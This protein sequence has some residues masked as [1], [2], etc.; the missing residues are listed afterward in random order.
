MKNWQVL[1]IAQIQNNK[2]KA[3]ARKEKCISMCERTN[4]QLS[5]KQ[6]Q[7]MMELEEFFS[8]NSAW[9]SQ[10]EENQTEEN[11]NGNMRFQVMKLGFQSKERSKKSSNQQSSE[12]LPKFAIEDFVISH[13]LGKGSSAVVKLATHK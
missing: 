7:A 11:K 10:Q 2:C 3:H 8:R 4:I 9:S 13:T 1:T 5:S 6:Q 12:L